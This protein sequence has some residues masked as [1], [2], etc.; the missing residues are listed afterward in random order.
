MQCSTQSV[1]DQMKQWRSSQGLHSCFTKGVPQPSHAVLCK[2]KG[3]SGLLPLLSWFFPYLTSW[4]GWLRSSLRLWH[5]CEGDMCSLCTAVTL[6]LLR[7]HLLY[8]WGQ[9]YGPCSISTLTDILQPGPLWKNPACRL[10]SYFHPFPL[11]PQKNS[12]HLEINKNQRTR[13][14]NNTG[15]PLGVPQ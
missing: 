6:I 3:Q 2:R 8:Q 15:V 10:T 14:S 4:E 1:K 11:S 13:I 5:L 12:H 9:D 7:R